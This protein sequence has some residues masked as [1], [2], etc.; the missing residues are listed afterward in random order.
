MELSVIACSIDEPIVSN[1]HGKASDRTEK[2][3]KKPRPV[4][5]KLLKLTYKQRRELEGL[6][7]AIEQLE[8]QTASLHEEMAKPSFYKQDAEQITQ[9][10]AKLRSLDQKLAQA[11]SRWEELAAIE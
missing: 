5:D 2:P 10:S 11:Y 3:A 6:P 9:T 1:S 4:K 8:K 7:E